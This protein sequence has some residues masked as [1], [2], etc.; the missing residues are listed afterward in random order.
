LLSN[1]TQEIWRSCGPEITAIVEKE[2]HKSYVQISKPDYVIDRATNATVIPEQ[3]S[4]SIF[5]E[6]A[7]IGYNVYGGLCNFLVSLV[8]QLKE[9]ITPLVTKSDNTQLSIRNE[10][11]EF[12]RD[13]TVKAVVL[14]SCY[15]IIQVVMKQFGQ[16]AALYCE[17]TISRIIVSDKF[18]NTY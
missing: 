9:Q 4:K 3:Q 5:Q 10:K 11:Q 2:F 18:Y 7:D 1:V 6:A 8:H 16:E 14:L 15:L 13:I 17:E 12:V